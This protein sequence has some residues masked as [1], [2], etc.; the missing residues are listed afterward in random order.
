MIKPFLGQ[1]PYSCSICKAE[2]RTLGSKKAHEA[3]GHR[4]I[5][6]K[7][8]KKATKN[9]L[10]D[11]L[12]TLS[13]DLVTEKNKDQI[14]DQVPEFVPLETLNLVMTQNNVNIYIFSKIHS[15]T[16]TNCYIFFS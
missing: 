15:F 14:H 7:K 6:R 4:R 10:T 9:N 13:S 1:M 11:I 2:F 5:L 12:Q 3:V 8:V 16:I